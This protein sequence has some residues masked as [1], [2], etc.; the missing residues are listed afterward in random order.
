MHA[1]TANVDAAALSGQAS[2]S[3]AAAIPLMPVPRSE[4]D[5]LHGHAV[6][7]SMRD[8]IKHAEYLADSDAS[9][10]P[11]AEQLRLLAGSFQ[12]KALVALINA[13]RERVE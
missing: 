6:R 10:Q 1:E 11:F 2:T 12:T 9:Y 3:V 13:Y 5:I 4:L 7:G 8:V